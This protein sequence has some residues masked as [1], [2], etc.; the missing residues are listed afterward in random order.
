MSLRTPGLHVEIAVANMGLYPWDLPNHPSW[1]SNIEQLIPYLAETGCRNFEIHPTDAIV[2][3]VEARKRR[4]DTWLV[5]EV[6]G[7]LHQTFNNGNDVFGKVADR[8][9]VKRSVASVFSM[10]A[11]QGALSH[12]VP[13]V[14]YADNLPSPGRLTREMR[15]HADNHLPSTNSPRILS[16]IQPS[17][18][19]H[20]NHGTRSD[21]ELLRRMAEIGILGYCPDTVHAR[22][23]AEDGTKPPPIEVWAA[24]FASGHV[25]QMH[26][27]ADRV[28]MEKHNPELAAKS[29]QEFKAFMSRRWQDAR[30]T[31]MGDMIVAAIENWT[32]PTELARTVGVPILRNVIELPPRP[33]A[34]FRRTKEH[35]RFVENLAEVV[36]EAGATPLLWGAA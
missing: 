22:L 5:D 2:Q 31:E 14:Y 13:G 34:F 20:R 33:R 18:E 9:G 1:G 35:A 26:T 30:D 11:I 23:K 6:V 12:S 29:V 15:S 32:P 10:A 8:R 7:S 19:V 4:G 21:R 27:G 24:Q 3:D 36:R 28:D 16:T 25:Y 17:A